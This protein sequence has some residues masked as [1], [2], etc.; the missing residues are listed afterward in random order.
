MENF[1]YQTHSGV[2]WLVVLMTVVAFGWLLFRYVQ[3]QSYDKRT[4]IIMASWA[5]LIG[6]QWILGIVLMLVLGTFTGMQWSHAVILT[7]A[8][9]VAHVYVPLKKR[10]DKVRF[11]GGLWSIVTVG[12]LVFVGVQL[13]N[14]W[15]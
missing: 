12:V 14:G 4:H 7:I 6:L 13:V 3:N 15:A 8:L 5:G 11:M 1:L 2:R 10:P 9:A